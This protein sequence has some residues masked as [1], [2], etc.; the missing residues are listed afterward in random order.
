MIFANSLPP[1]KKK[2]GKVSH[3]IFL[4]SFIFKVLVTEDIEEMRNV[5]KNGEKMISRPLFHYS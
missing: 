1:K 4:L 3:T 5:N 2:S